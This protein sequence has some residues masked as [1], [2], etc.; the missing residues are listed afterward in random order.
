VLATFAL[1]FSANSG[2]VPVVFRQFENKKL[3]VEK[4][5]TVLKNGSYFTEIKEAFLAKQKMFSVGLLILPEPK[6]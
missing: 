5:F 4:L 1:S 6:K 2:R 3:N